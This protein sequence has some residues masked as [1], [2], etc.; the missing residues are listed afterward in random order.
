MLDILCSALY[1]YGMTTAPEVGSKIQ[2]T[3]TTATQ[4]TVIVEITAID[5]EV[6]AGWYVYGYRKHRGPRPR[7]TMYPR[8]YFVAKT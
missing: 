4:Q 6:E 5:S 2:A 1:G 8:L 7:Q 3:T